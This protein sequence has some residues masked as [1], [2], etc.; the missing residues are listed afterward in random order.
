MRADLAA[1]LAAL[2][3]E[4]GA[5]ETEPVALDGGITNRNFRLT[6]GGR[7]HGSSQTGG[8]DV[9]RHNAPCTGGRPRQQ[10]ALGTVQHPDHRHVRQ[11]TPQMR[12]HRLAGRAGQGRAGQHHVRPQQLDG[13]DRRLELVHLGCGSHRYV[14][15]FC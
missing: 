10:L 1:A 15:V 2:E 5:A 3:P 13:L 6:A 11:G 7:H 14:A 4:I 8:V 12:D 9:G